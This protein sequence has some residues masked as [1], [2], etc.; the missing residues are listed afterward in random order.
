MEATDIRTLL[1]KSIE[2]LPE[3]HKIVLSLY[4]HDNLSLWD[5]SRAMDIA[6]SEVYRLYLEAVNSLPPNLLNVH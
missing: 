1:A 6:P 2:E 4:Y 5:I 3:Q